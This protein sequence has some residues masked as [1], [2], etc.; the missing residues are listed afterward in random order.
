LISENPEI[1]CITIPVYARLLG[2]GELAAMLVDIHSLYP[3]VPIGKVCIELSA[4]ILYEDL[5]AASEW[6]DQLRELGVKVAICEVGDQFCPVFRLSEIKF[7]YAFM[8]SY[9]TDSLDSDSAERIAGSLVKYLHYL[10]AVVIAPGLD[11]EAR[12]ESAKSLG[13]DGYT[14][15]ARENPFAERGETADG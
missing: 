3:E 9:S 13:A 14:A 6:I 12:I 15:D 7:D 8:D 1:S 11:T 10:N 2:D 4:D 5:A